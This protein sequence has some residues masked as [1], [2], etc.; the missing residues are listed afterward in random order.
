MY[1][2][3]NISAQSYLANK[4]NPV[5][6]WA[7]PRSVEVEVFPTLLGPS[8]FFCIAPLSPLSPVLLAAN[9]L[10]LPC[11]AAY[12]FTHLAPFAACSSLPHLACCLLLILSCLPCL[13]HLAAC[14]SCLHCCLLLLQHLAQLASPHL[15]ACCCTVLVALLASPSLLLLSTLLLLPHLASP[16]CCLLLPILLLAAC[17]PMEHLSTC[18][19]GRTF[20][21]HHLS[22]ATLSIE[23]LKCKFLIRFPHLTK[24]TWPLRCAMGAFRWFW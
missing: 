15:A 2:Y 11:I 12:C 23:F 7:M 17:T 20:W 9:L 19:P 21:P 24:P 10:L 4:A 5:A 3:E 1:S 6:H 18:Q 13:P 22:I 8:W 16:S 14:F